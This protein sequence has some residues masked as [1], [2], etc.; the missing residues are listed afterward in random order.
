MTEGEHRLGRWLRQQHFEWLG[1]QGHSAKVAA[2]TKLL[3]KESWANGAVQPA[4]NE[5]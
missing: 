2:V 5:L 1:L 3:S 4:G